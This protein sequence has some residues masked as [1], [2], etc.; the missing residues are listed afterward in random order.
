[1]SATIGAGWNYGCGVRTAI[2]AEQLQADRRGIFVPTMGALHEGH[3]ALIRAAAALRDNAAGERRLP[4]IVSLFVNRTQ[5]NDP[6]DYARYPKTLEA[7][8]DLCGA[9]GAD[10]VFVPEHATVYPPGTVIGVPSLPAVAT[11]PGLEDALRP[12]HFDGVCQVVKRLFELVDPSHALFGE[13]DWQQLAVI[14]AMTRDL[15]LPVAIHAVPT[16][17]EPDGLAMSS[18]NRFMSP[19]E[20][21]IAPTVYRA[22]AAGQQVS[23]PGRA[24]AA[25]V[26]VLRAGGLE[27]QYAVIR[28]AQTLAPIDTTKPGGPGRALIAC[29]LGTIRLIDNA[30]WPG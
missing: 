9:A 25:M 6:A 12:G 15:R 24:E 3:A 26:E 17:R 20:R 7:D 11:E 16:V 19:A 18:R 5:F 27:V 14:S 22:L 10:V 29:K 2:T 1:M 30:P 8:A 21:A 28:Q 13:K 23:S 4:V